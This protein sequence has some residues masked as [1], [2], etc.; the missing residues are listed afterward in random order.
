[1]QNKNSRIKVKITK[2][3]IYIYIYIILINSVLN[4]KKRLVI[5]VGE[6]L[7]PF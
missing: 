7:I 4:K 2:K 3:Y 1:M 5:A 6:R